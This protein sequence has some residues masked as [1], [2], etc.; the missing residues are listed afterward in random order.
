M[1]PTQYRITNSRGLM[2]RQIMVMSNLSLL[3]TTEVTWAWQK[4]Q[5]MFFGWESSGLMIICGNTP[6]GGTEAWV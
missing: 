1:T 6:R 5:V 4:V 2:R 3:A